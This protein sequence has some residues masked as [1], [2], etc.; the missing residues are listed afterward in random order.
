MG[1]TQ[2]R[3]DEEEVLRVRGMQR[4]LVS[5]S[6]LWDLC[7]TQPSLLLHVTGIYNIR[8]Q[9]SPNSSEKI[10]SPFVGDIITYL[11]FLHTTL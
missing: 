6:A 2:E 3:T 10:V 4:I 8:A 9:L 1:I 7:Q 5:L 11:M